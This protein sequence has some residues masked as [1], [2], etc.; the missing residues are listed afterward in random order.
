MHQY[1]LQI[2]SG[3]I[4]IAPLLALIVCFVASELVQFTVQRCW[5]GAPAKS[6]ASLSALIVFPV[7]A[8]V[9]FQWLPAAT[10][11]SGLGVSAQ[12]AN[13]YLMTFDVPPQA[14][15]VDYRH[16]F[17]DGLTDAADFD[18][19]EAE[20][21]KWMADS[22]RQPHHFSTVA[23]QIRWDDG[24]TLDRPSA[25]HVHQVAAQFKHQGEIE[26]EQGYYFDD[27]AARGSVDNGLTVVYDP[28]KKR[29]YIW[30]T[31]Y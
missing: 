2:M 5:R 19:S 23:Y 16:S 6:L 24:K 4:I 14:T 30:R 1:P 18:I 22:D 17:F 15:N 12:A 13:E 20:F 21:L 27:Y 3:L 29:A 7:V 25:I 9:L 10:T 8:A 31:T 28:Q 26:I 11:H